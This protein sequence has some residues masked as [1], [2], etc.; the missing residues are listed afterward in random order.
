MVAE[1]VRKRSA[2]LHRSSSA[3][4]TLKMA[5][6]APIPMASERMATRANIGDRR[7]PR[8]A[9]MSIEQIVAALIQERNRL[10]QAIEAYPKEDAPGP[11]FEVCLDILYS[12]LRQTW[13]INETCRRS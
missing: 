10:E 3:F 7:S 12:L 9:A 2:F 5:E 11:F 8:S 1:W 13:S 6:F 4:T